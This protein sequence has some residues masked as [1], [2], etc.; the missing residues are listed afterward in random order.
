MERKAD[1]SKTEDFPDKSRIFRSWSV[2]A[3]LA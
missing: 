1:E 2:Y 3:V